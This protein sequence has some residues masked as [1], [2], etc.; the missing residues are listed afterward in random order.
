MICFSPVRF[1][2][3]LKLPVERFKLWKTDSLANLN[4]LGSDVVQYILVAETQGLDEHV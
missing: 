2:W 3:I 1:L 4:E